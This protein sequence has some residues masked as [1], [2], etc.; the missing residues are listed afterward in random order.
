M[1]RWELRELLWVKR[2][3]IQY[4]PFEVTLGGPICLNLQI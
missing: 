4:Y 2:I 3:E 1:F